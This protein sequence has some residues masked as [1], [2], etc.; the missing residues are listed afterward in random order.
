MA[1][2]RFG[3]L[4][5]ESQVDSSAG[6]TF[7][8]CLCDC[9]TY[10]II[11]GV[12]LKSGDTR[13]CGCLEKENQRYGSIIH[14]ATIGKQLTKEF[15]AWS[16]AKARCYSPNCKNFP[17]YGGRGITMCQDWLESYEAFLTDMGPRPNGFSLDRI[18]VD[19]NYEPKNCRWAST[20]TQANN[21]RS[22]IQIGNEKLSL[23]EISRRVGVNYKAL[24]HL[25]HRNKLSL[26]AAI[27]RLTT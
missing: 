15:I 23:K 9:G 1:G 3:R 6:S 17:Q 2:E 13:S 4:Q 10:K 7:W 20:F 22:N 18:N 5:V 12:Y 27:L 16:H 19:G 8:N 11:K 25:Y 21:K 24:H 26:S 14:G